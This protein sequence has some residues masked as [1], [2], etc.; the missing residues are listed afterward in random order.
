VLDRPQR[1]WHDLC[2]ESCPGPNN[3]AAVP[4]FVQVAIKDAVAAAAAVGRKEDK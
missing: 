3:D 4:V 2:V 1:Q